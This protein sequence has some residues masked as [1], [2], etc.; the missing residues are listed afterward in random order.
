MVV[1]VSVENV[2]YLDKLP[3]L[4]LII[5]VSDQFALLLL[6]L[7]GIDQR[8]FFHILIYILLIWK[9]KTSLPKVSV[10]IVISIGVDPKVSYEDSFIFESEFRLHSTYSYVVEEMAELL[11]LNH[12]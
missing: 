7:F 8:S 1:I 11:E 12:L 10:L 4:I 3:L 2:C 6:K 5:I 9:R